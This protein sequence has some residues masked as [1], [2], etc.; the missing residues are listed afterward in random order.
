MRRQLR[1]R[2][3]GLHVENDGKAIDR[4]AVDD[5]MASEHGKSFMRTCAEAWGNA[6]AAS[7]E[8]SETAHA[9]VSR[10]AEAYTAS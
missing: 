8:R 7:G 1:G 10:T 4:E 9:M 2:W 5:W 3:L 6:H